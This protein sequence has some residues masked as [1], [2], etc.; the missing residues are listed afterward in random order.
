MK[1]YYD[2]LGL[3]QSASVDDIKFKCNFLRGYFGYLSYRNTNGDGALFD[4]RLKEIQEAYE[5]LINTERRNI[6]DLEYS[7][8]SE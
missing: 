3:K 4:E 2:L 6:Y 8:K 7:N 5:V 1:D